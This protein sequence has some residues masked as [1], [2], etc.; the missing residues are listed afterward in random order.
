MGYW[1]VFPSGSGG[2]GSGD[3]SGPV[4]VI[5]GQI[6]VFDGVTGDVVRAG[7]QI[8]T[9]SNEVLTLDAQGR[10]PAVDGS[11][12]TGITSTLSG[13]SSGDLEGDY[14][15]ITVVAIQGNAVTDNTPGDNQVYLW[16]DAS[17][18]FV[19]S[20][21]TLSVAGFTGIVTTQQIASALQSNIP[22]LAPQ[23]RSF[24]TT[25]PRRI[26]P[27]T[28]LTGNIYEARYNLHNSTG[29]S[30]V[31]LVG[32]LTSTPESPT[33]IITASTIS[34]G[35]NSLSFVF[36]P[37]VS[38][39]EGVSYTL[40]LQIF[41]ATQ[42]PGVDAAI[43]TANFD[44]IA[45]TT[46]IPELL[47]WGVT[48]E[49][50]A[51]NIDVLPFEHQSELSGDVTLPTWTGSL[52]LAFVYP[53]SEPAVTALTIDGI[54]QLDGFIATPNSLTIEG[55]LHTVLLSRNQLR[56]SLSGATATITR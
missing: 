1:T 47:Y 32:F 22:S 44:I 55:V 53:S 49:T 54:N 25:A 12:V 19:V 14:P 38:F 10:L 16:R 29:I 8:G 51:G 37:A 17:S 18:E 26:D 9:A 36:L 24:T 35:D 7:P 52:Y 46:A 6:V 27:G 50:I 3:I 39:T 42:T 11:L 4:S 31:R 33:T 41:G 48:T 13:A 2:G 40:Q 56:S 34:E 43:D 30:T 21:V 28:D 5:D 23:I 45:Q 15:D 20:N